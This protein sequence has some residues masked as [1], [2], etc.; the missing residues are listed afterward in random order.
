MERDKGDGPVV[1]ITERLE[2]LQVNTLSCESS[3]RVSLVDSTS[4]R[5]LVGGWNRNQDGG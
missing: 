1:P 4:C 5:G 2:G 3:N